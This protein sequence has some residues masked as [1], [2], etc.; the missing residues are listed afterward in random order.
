MASLG[1]TGELLQGESG[2]RAGNG[3]AAEAMAAGAV[4]VHPAE[5]SCAQMILAAARMFASQKIQT[6]AVDV[7]SAAQQLGWVPGFDRNSV[8]GLLF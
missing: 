3:A 7:E 1:P 2:N 5:L 4:Q 6:L 8:W